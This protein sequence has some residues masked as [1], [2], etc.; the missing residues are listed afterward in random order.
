MLLSLGQKIAS[1]ISVSVT[2]APRI[3]TFIGMEVKISEL[4]KYIFN[5]PSLFSFGI[6]F[7]SEQSQLPSAKLRILSFYNLSFQNK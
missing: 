7:Q 6:M 4:P 3:D 1:V 5:N 2:I